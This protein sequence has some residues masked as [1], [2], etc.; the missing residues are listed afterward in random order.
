M[1]NDTGVL[2]LC[3]IYRIASLRSL[4]YSHSLGVTYAG[5]DIPVFDWLSGGIYTFSGF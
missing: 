3:G 2:A 4:S 5:M 1:V